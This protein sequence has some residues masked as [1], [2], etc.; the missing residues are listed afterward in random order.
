VIE[1]RQHLA[2]T[3]HY[4]QDSAQLLHQLLHINCI[5]NERYLVTGCQRAVLFAFS[6]R[7]TLYVFSKEFT[8]N[9]GENWERFRKSHTVCK[10][11]GKEGSQWSSCHYVR[12][13]RTSPYCLTY[14]RQTR[15]EPSPASSYRIWQWPNKQTLWS[16]SG[17]SSENT[18]VRS[19]KF[20]RSGMSPKP[21]ARGIFSSDNAMHSHTFLASSLIK[22]G[23][24]VS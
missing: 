17:D 12:A 16:A 22:G 2:T 9:E 3:H 7:I 4:E 13:H 6:L 21:R 5:R 11:S 23:S 18:Y 19:T 8:T 1:C 10:P 14:K 20:C 24:P 15:W